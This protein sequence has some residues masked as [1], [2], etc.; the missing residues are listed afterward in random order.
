[1]K[2]VLV[3]ALFATG[4]SAVHHGRFQQVRVQTD[5]AGAAVRVACGGAEEIRVTPVVLRLHRGAQTC[6]LTLTKSG[7]RA[8]RVLLTTSVEKRFWWNFVP[9]GMAIPISVSRAGDQTFVDFLAGAGLTG[10][11]L[12][13]D[14]IS[15]AMWVL[16]PREVSLKL[17]PEQQ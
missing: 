1:M 9:V 5:P 4:C 15:D 2:R 6:N 7:Y 8:E 16:H 3:F 17:V 13:V 11:A 10:A 12:A 14:A